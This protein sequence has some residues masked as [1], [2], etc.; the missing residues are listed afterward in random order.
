MSI[1]SSLMCGLPWVS[2]EC[3]RCSARSL[4]SGW[5]NS[6]GSQNSDLQNACLAQYAR[7]CFLSG[8]S[9]SHSIHAQ[10]SIQ[11]RRKGTPCG[12]LVLLLSA[13]S[14]SPVICSTNPSCPSCLKRQSLLPLSRKTSV[15]SL[16]STLYA[17]VWKVPTAKKLE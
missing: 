17:K 12:F 7:S 16:D 4:H 11:S 9:E 15:L 8:S 2:A 5:S 6:T 13:L 10:L 1:D 14:K 3:L